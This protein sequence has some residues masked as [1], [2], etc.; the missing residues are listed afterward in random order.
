MGRGIVVVVVVLILGGVSRLVADGET[1]G[2]VVGG[3]GHA[4]GW[5]PTDR[6]TDGHTGREGAVGG[7]EAGLD[8]IL[9]LGLGDEGLELGGGEGVYETRL[10]YDEEQDLG[11]GEGGEL[12]CLFH[13]ASFPFGERYMT[14]RL[15]LDKFNLD[16]SA[17][18]LLV[19]LG[20]AVL[21][22]IVLAGAVDGVVVVD[23]GVVADLAWRGRV[24]L[25]DVGGV[26]VEGPLP[27][28]H[29]GRC[30][31]GIGGLGEGRRFGSVKRGRCG[32]F[33][34]DEK[35]TSYGVW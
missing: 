5:G 15:V 16:L 17:P 7:I 35:R 9:A 10:W 24:L 6:R 34:L 22:L 13:N 27:L 3:R 31:G 25:G 21:L 12:V 30:G 26:E 8:E 29:R 18:S 23:E 2:E 4:H 19:G 32:K 28:A 20:L 33:V 14:S 11:T 1:P